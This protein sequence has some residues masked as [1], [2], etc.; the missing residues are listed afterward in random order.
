MHRICVNFHGNRYVVDYILH[1][2]FFFNKKGE[3]LPAV[4]DWIANSGYPCTLRTSTTVDH[5][6][7]SDKK[8]TVLA[9]YEITFKTREH[10]N[11]F[12]EAFIKYHTLVITCHNFDVKKYIDTDWR[13]PEHVREWCKK[14]VKKGYHIKRT[15]VVPNQPEMVELHIDFVD[16]IEAAKY[17]IKWCGA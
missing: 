7:V 8:R 10:A 9:H 1:E 2:A 12:K 5:N 14:E 4:R 16:E 3:L 6:L 13:F 15:N 11:E 17:K